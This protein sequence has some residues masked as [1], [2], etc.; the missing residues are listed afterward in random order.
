[1]NID[2]IYIYFNCYYIVIM[3]IP[4]TK[5]SIK[6]EIKYILD[7]AKNGWGKNCYNYINKF[8]DELSKYLGVKYV[9]ATLVAL[10]QFT[11]H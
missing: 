6:T 3:K 9:I 4:I 1:M 11:Y 5:P 7:A 10:E 2:K 8:E